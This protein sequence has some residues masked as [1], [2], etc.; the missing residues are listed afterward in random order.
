[1]GSSEIYS[2]V[3]RKETLALISTIFASLASQTFSVL[4]H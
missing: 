2:A 3:V 1:M 4:Q